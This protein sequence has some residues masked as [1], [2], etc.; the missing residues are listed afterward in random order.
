MGRNDQISSARELQ[1]YGKN[2][3]ERRERGY[4]RGDDAYRRDD[5]RDWERRDWERRY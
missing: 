4:Y 5:R 1:H 3:E 2:Y